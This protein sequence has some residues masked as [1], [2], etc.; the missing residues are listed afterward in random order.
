MNIF[1]IVIIII[2]VFLN[3]INIYFIIII[4]DENENEGI[5]QGYYPI[6]RGMVYFIPI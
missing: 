1:F 4:H 3:I 5:K 2:V 6:N